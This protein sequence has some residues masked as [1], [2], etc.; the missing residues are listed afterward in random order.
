MKW[1]KE[2]LRNKKEKANESEKF[3]QDYQIKG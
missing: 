1:K 2:K 3:E